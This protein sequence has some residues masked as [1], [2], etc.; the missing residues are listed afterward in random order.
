MSE[1]IEL[2]FLDVGD[3]DCTIIEF[4]SGRLCVIDICT[5]NNETHIV[6]YLRRNFPGKYEIFRF[7]LTHP[8]QD[9]LHGLKEMTDA[10]Y[11]IT[12]FWH[13]DHDFTPDKS[14]DNWKEYKAHWNKYQE[15]VGTKSVRTYKQGNQ[16][17]YLID[18]GIEILSPCAHMDNE[19]K[20]IE[21]DSAI[22]RNNYVLRISYGD[23]SAILSGDADNP[24]WNHLS[25]EFAT[26]LKSTLWKVPH[27]GT[28]KYWHEDAAKKIK[29][30]IVIISAGE[31]Y[32][33]HTA[34]EEYQKLTK[35]T[36]NTQR[37]GN[38]K[39]VS[40]YEGNVEFTCD[41]NSEDFE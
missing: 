17:Q 7:I 40:D 25:D 31:S 14:S 12:N 5:K 19:A 11:T 10:G 22:H 6:D 16:V 23:F 3:G 38:I 39:I 18:D 35:Y 1:K 34:M 28:E 32:N 24:C 41:Q 2:H 15:I 9:H 20:D 21:A 30:T 27:H 4:P 13:T 33:E 36:F 8:H 26:K 29:P 37:H